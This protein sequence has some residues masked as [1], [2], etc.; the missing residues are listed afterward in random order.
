[1]LQ[2]YLRE[3]MKDVW[4]IWEVFVEKF[5]DSVQYTDF[6]EIINSKSIVSTGKQIKI[7]KNRFRNHLII[8]YALIAINMIFIA[9]VTGVVIY[10]KSRKKNSK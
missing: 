6:V 3:V 10:K 2:G 8:I 5:W 1:M 7:V 4:R 9:S